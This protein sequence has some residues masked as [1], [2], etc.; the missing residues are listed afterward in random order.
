MISEDCENGGHDMASA[1]SEEKKPKTKS[2]K[3]RKE[4]EPVASVTEN[5]AYGNGVEDFVLL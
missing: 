4:P 1:A 5:I 3:K 2:K